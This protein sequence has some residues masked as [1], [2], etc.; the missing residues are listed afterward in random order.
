[1]S[2]LW[3]ALAAH[4]DARPDAVALS[5]GQVDIPYGG[6]E[7]AV[8]RAAKT[9]DWHLAGARPGAPVALA[10]DN[11]PAW[12]LI[13]L[14]LLKLER[15]CLP[16]PPFF[17]EAQRGHAI[18]DGGAAMVVSEAPE[19]A[20]GT[21]IAAGRTL[22][23]SPTTAGPRRLPDGTAKIT[24]T[25]GSTGA[26]KGVCLSA[27]Q[28]EAVAGSLVD[29]IGRDRAGVHLSLLPLGVLLE[30][31][32]G[33][34]A[35]LIAGG[36][37]HAPPAAACGL[38]NP[39]KPDLMAMARAIADSQATSL[40]LVPEMLRG[41][42]AVMAGSGLRLP[43]LG[44]VA[45]GGAKVAPALIEAAQALN[46]PVFEGYGLTECASVVAVNTPA[47]NRAGTV[48]RV[49][50]H[51]SVTLSAD[52][53][54][55]V[56]PEG[57]L[58]YVGEARR[59]GPVLT[60]DL[61]E[62]TPDGFLRITGRRDNLIV[63]SYGRN[64]S[65]EWVE[66]ELLSQPEIMQ[67]VVFGEAREALSA[68]LVTHPTA[69]DVAVSMAVAQANGR[70]P[71]YARVAAWRCVPPFSRA[72]GHLTGNG[73]PRRQALLAAYREFLTPACEV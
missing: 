3:S 7:A 16:L 48:G 65:P 27:A 57:F 69:S 12:A 18:A 31:I 5:D 1:M 34:Y 67:A 26:P 39:F 51:L 50:P 10:L 37:H 6:L 63:S 71:E 61:G 21:M 72:D 64:V 13:D 47:H 17:T 42:M 2:L 33:L 35:A 62:R 43:D 73:R 53:E 41:L 52:A 59:S 24:Y 19:G 70:L 54:V 56:G 25:S 36:R 9:L 28:M 68:L 66:S 46:L 38:A 11:S 4:A 14:A 40:I 23:L 44:F 32:G 58:G 45:V 15:P 60:G 49:L 29:A 55:I 30:N 22:R 20:A 8:D